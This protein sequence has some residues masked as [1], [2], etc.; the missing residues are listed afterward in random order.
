MTQD[1]LFQA[2][3][4]EAE[5]A[6]GLRNKGNLELFKAVGQRVVRF[7]IRNPNSVSITLSSFVCLIYD[8]FNRNKN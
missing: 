1:A 4:E 6:L 2:W 3:K 8:E 5:M 7:C